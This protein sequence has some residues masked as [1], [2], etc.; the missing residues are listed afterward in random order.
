MKKPII[1]SILVAILALNMLPTTVFAL[2]E[3][4]TETILETYADDDLNNEQEQS[5][6]NEN[7]STNYEVTNN[8]ELAAALEQV[9]TSAATEAVIVLKNDVVAPSTPED[10][11]VTSFGVAGKHITV[12]SKDGE[13]KKLSFSSRGILTGDCTFDNIDVIGSRLYCNGYKT[14]FTENGQ[15]HLD[16]TLYGGG[17]KTTVANTYVVIASTGYINP[18]SSSGLHNVI[19]GSYQGSV[20]G[21]TYLKITGDIEM[22]GGNHL[23]PGCVKGDGTSGDATNIPDVYV[24][25]N[26][27]LI[28]DNQNGATTPTIEGTYGCEM[29][30]NVTLDIRSGRANE[31]CGTQEFVDTSIIRGDLHIIAGSPDYEN[32]DRTLRLNANWPI[33]GA[34]NCF[35]TFPGAVGNY[36]VGGDITI[37]TYEN[38]WS[39]DKG[40]DPTTDHDKWNDIP[41]IYGAIRGNV[42][43]SITI[44]AHGS[45]VENISGASDSSTVGGDVTINAT[46]VELK[47]SEYNTEYDE[48]DIYANY[49]SIINGKCAINVDGGDVNIIQLTNFK[50]INEGS[51]ITITGSPKIRTGVVST[52]NFDT[53]PENVAV[54]LTDCTATIPFIQSSTHTH[55]TNNSD[56]KLNGLWLTGSLT[57]DEGSILKTDDLD[58]ME[59]SGNVVVNGTWEQL[60]IN[61]SRA[62]AYDVTIAGTMT[63]GTSGKYIGHGSTHV[64]GDVSSCGMMALMKP[65]EFGGNYAGANAELRLPA[66]VTNYTAADIPLKIG[67]LST[68]TT[69]V[70][71][72]D[73]EDWNTLKKPVLGD[74]YI[75]SKKNTDAPAQ[76]VFLL[77]NEDAILDN[78]YLKRMNDADGTD[79]YYMWQVA[80]GVRVIF[81]K[82]G[83]DTEASPRIMSQEKVAGSANHFD[84]PTTNPTRT[85]YLFNGWNTKAD[86]AGAVFTAE[87]DVT[88]NMTVYAQWKPDEAYA[89]KI[90]PMNLTVYVGGDGYQG[91]IG[92]DGKFDA[93]DLPEIGFYITLPDDINTML[94]GTDE[95]PVDLSDKLRLTSDDDSGTMRSWSLELYS[96]ES[97]SH[98]I[99]NG[100]RVYIYKLRQIDDGEE[101]VPRVQF[102]GADGSVMTE[103]K[104]QA[105]LTDQFRNYKISVYQGLLDEQIYK[106]TLTAD[107]QTFTRPIKLGT[108][109]LKVRGNNDT[110]YRAIENNTIP[111][112]NPQ[113][114]GIMLVSTAQTDTQ[115]YINNS[116]ISVPSSDD[117]K[118][119]VDHSLDDALLSAYINRTFNTEGKYSY[120][121][122]YLDLVDTSNGNTYVT[123][124][125]GQKMN[126]YWPVPSDAKSNSELRIIHFKGID[127]D[128]DTDVNELLTTRIPEEL[129]CET[130]TIGGQKFVKFA[131]DSFSPFALLYEKEIPQDNKIH[132]E[133]IGTDKPSD[134]L[135]PEDEH[136]R[137]GTAYTS[138]KQEDTAENYIFEGWFTDEDCSNKYIDGT[139]LNT[140]IILYG[141]W[142]AVYGN[143]TVNKKVAGTY[144]DKNQEFNF[145]VTLSKPVNG[146]YGD[147]TF[148]DGEANFTLKHDESKK[149]VNLPANI[150]YTV[151]EDDYSKD[152]YTTTSVNSTGT[153]TKDKTT[154]VNFTN[155]K[156]KKEVKEDKVENNKPT[157]TN[158]T[159]NYQLVQTDTRN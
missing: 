142:I 105:L 34:G 5:T 17:Y 119:M 19:G 118:L 36:T 134:V 133:W 14:I 22:Q 125:A 138:Q 24:G 21:D 84:L 28:Y 111:S 73:P 152:G 47:N 60:F 113:E 11:Y 90:A 53:T 18:S 103:S 3:D 117:V 116:G 141:K 50:Q 56:V 44:N 71:T 151:V 59:L 93:N 45:H 92:E 153:I 159:T 100:R 89:V 15:I 41:E 8:D 70:N 97:K 76:E 146:T 69:T 48:G 88:D 144:G 127:R 79:D 109:T 154:E 10:T 123:M 147:M 131:V 38:V 40:V 150:S 157:T 25:G 67:G 145:K 37:D 87:T 148:T 81:D 20:E 68:G 61:S 23:T 54:T 112:V 135:P 122:R 98:V 51:Q 27:T 2:T 156:N 72:V 83:G 149:G 139:T 106:A 58:D 136:I 115:Y 31:I 86:G 39:W 16:E 29:R 130:V 121:F 55:V 128:S 108:G 126:L 120:Q 12:K 95:N 66:V 80:N 158:V 49:N 57:V 143:L 6:E 99:E 114:K 102:T 26:A 129:T 64:A 42:G 52:S 43:G 4:T 9:A 62:A 124:G 30:G 74:N 32:T 13:M 77:G 33:V 91:V 137:K 140:D 85:G 7:S 75:L 82:N 104:F 1:T 155:T 35:A 94:G 107:G 65:A 132:Y 63:V 101:T 110:T 46:N 78:L 96:D